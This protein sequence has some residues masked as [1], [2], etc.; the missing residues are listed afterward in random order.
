M[1]GV[2]GGALQAILNRFFMLFFFLSLPKLAFPYDYGVFIM[3]QNEEDLL[4]LLASGEIDQVT[5]DTLIELM[6]KPV[7]LNKASR[8]EIYSL[9]NLSYEDVDKILLYRD[10]VVAIAD[11][12]DLVVG[13]GLSQDKVM[14]L[15]PFIVLSK[16]KPK[17][18]ETK[19]EAKYSI[20]T[21]Y[22][23]TETPPMLFLAKVRSLRYWHFGTALLV[24]KNRLGEVRF[25]E[26]RQALVAEPPKTR[27]VPAKYFVSFDDNKW[28]II[29][30]TFVIGFGERLTLDNTGLEFP[31]GAKE[32]TSVY[33]TYEMQVACKESKAD[34]EPSCRQE[35]GSL[36][37]QPDYR[38]TKGFRGVVI[39]LRD[40]SLGAA[41][42]QAYAFASFQ[43]NDIYQYEIYDSGV[44]TDPTSTN[45]ECK[46]PWVY[47]WQ[48]DPFLPTTRF[49][50]STLPD[51]YDEIVTGGNLSVFL[52]KR[53][54]FGFTGY[55]SKVRWLVEGMDLDFQEWS[56]MPYGGDFGAVGVN[57]SFG[58]GLSD[59]HFEVARSFDHMPERGGW[60]GIGRAIFS[61]LNHELEFI[62]RWYGADYANP[63][64]RAFSEPDEY[65]GL[66]ARDESGA[67][68]KYVGKF[69]RVRLR[70]FL[71]MW[72]SAQI[73]DKTWRLKTVGRVDI[74]M[75]KLVTPFAYVRFEDKDL[76][77]SSRGSCFDYSRKTVEGET[78]PCTGERIDFGCGVR[79]KPVKNLSMSLNLQYR[80]VDDSKLA[81]WREFRQD[82]LGVARLSYR[83]LRELFLG[84]YIRYLYEDV[85]DNKYLEQSITSVI[86]AQGMIS[87]LWRH[88]G[89][90][91]RLRYEI[92]ALLDKRQSTTQRWP[93]PAHFFTF[94]LMYKF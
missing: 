63:H 69:G 55:Y 20:T 57:G 32:D 77:H 14:A 16:L 28:Q 43:R 44:C 15:R 58:I 61:W 36:Y 6:S 46:A 78:I 34:I 85:K 51:M 17:R 56:R 65:G 52:N 67:A 3:V 80:L 68:I 24:S 88:E 33:M 22:G 62:L 9:P 7:D 10:D 70:Y 83:P 93:N 60:A 94:D 49:S 2:R 84:G 29:A 13:A 39:G 86:Y 5:Y 35:Q 27:F 72:T 87:S 42:L 12:T 48:G 91:A 79:L 38:F 21:S 25:D 1:G 31:N 4:E 81:I 90:W 54:H 53:T 82:F 30:G 11:L 37:E 47:K 8:E 64:S 18:F 26:N 74:R 23:D 41:D 73:A 75:N 66:R 89:L 40:V 19:G 76:R 50:Y 92:Y 71:D 45:E 59:L